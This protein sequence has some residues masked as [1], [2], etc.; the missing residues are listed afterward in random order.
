MPVWPVDAAMTHPLFRLLSTRY[1]LPEWVLVPEVRDATGFAASRTADALAMNCYPSKGLEVHGFEFKT[2]RSDW[3]RELRDG[4]KAEAVAQHCER[5]WIVATEGVVIRAELPT[6]W[7]LIVAKDDALRTVVAAPPLREKHDG[8]IDRYLVASFLR[9]CLERAKKPTED[10]LRAAGEAAA[11]AQRARDEDRIE[12]D[13][14]ESAREAD[15][16][17]G[18]IEA[19]EKASG[20]RVS[21]YDGERVGEAFAAFL[22]LR[23]GRH[24]DPIGNQAKALR[25]MADQLEAIRGVV[26]GAAS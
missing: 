9:G 23:R 21:S 8:T 14:K 22:A 2:A 1:T 17:R 10:E 20:V 6:T 13:R 19:F 11:K 3:L 4:S 24:F 18:A 5:W 25:E 15:R 7:G 12:R 26:D 16:L